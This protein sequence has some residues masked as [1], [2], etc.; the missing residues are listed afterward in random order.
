MKF[1]GFLILAILSVAS[2]NLL[3][4]ED[5]SPIVTDRPTQTTGPGVVPRGST[6]LE[7]GLAFT[8]PERVKPGESREIYSWNTLTRISL[9]D[10]IELRVITQP[11]IHSVYQDGAKAYNQFVFADLQGG[12]KFAIL[13]KKEGRPE[14]GLVSQVALPTRGW[15]KVRGNYGLINALAVNHVLTPKQSLTWNLGYDYYGVDNGNL[16][17]SLNWSISIINRFSFFIEHY[18]NF[19][20]M[21][22]LKAG[23]DVGVLYLLNKNLQLDYTFGTGLNYPGYFH[24]AGVSI[25]FRR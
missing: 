10:R 24:T 14:V 21:R 3:A 22:V 16:F 25:L 8:K 17:Y 19:E 15:S 5:A 1:K 18:A 12:F 2:S 11:E 9:S 4:Q 13:E 20:N 6:Q 7:T 23:A